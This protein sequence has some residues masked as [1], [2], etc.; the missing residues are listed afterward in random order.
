MCGAK[1]EIQLHHVSHRPAHD[2]CVLGDFD[3]VIPHVYHLYLGPARKFLR[4]GYDYNYIDDE[5]ILNCSME[6]GRLI[7]GRTAYSVIVMA[8]TE[9]VDPAV[10]AKLGEFENAGGR[11][12]WVGGV[13]E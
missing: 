3:W 7:C 13:P 5:S 11:L 1:M 12:I 4:A 6:G 9:A 2:D 8:W 10:L